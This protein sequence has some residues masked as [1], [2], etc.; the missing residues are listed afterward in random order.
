MMGRRQVT[1]SLGGLLV[2]AALG[3]C[4]GSDGGSGPPSL[5]SITVAPSTVTL[6][7]G[8]SQSFAATGHFSDNSTESVA[9]TWSATGG[10]ITSAGVYTAGTTPGEYRVIATA[11]GGALADTAAVTIPA[12]PPPNLVAIEVTPPTATVAAGQSQTFTALG[13]LSDNSTTAVPVAWT[14][15]G[16]TVS[17]GGVYTAGSTAGSFLVIATEIGGAA[18]ADTATVTV[19]VSGPVLIGV[20]ITTDSVRAH[21]RDTATVAAVGRYSNNTEGPVTVTWSTTA[22][23]T[24]GSISPTGTFTATSAALGAYKIIATSG[25]YADTVPVVTFET[26][27]VTVSGPTFWLPTAP[28]GPTVGPA[29]VYLCTSNHYTDDAAGLGG[30]ATVTATPNVGVLQPTVSYTTNAATVYADGS[31]EVSVVC[32]KVWEA[33]VGLAGTVNVSISVASNRPGSGM[34]K[35]FTY[36][37]NAVGPQSP[38]YPTP[39]PSGRADFVTQQDFTPNMT[40]SV[41]T[42]SYTV[43]ASVGANI[44]FKST[45]VP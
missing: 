1:A 24:A 26:A 13:R 45:H 12:P 6:A 16:G 23:L 35:I 32:Q 17:A 18:F 43:S 11:Q 29:A 33:P 41:V 42:E 8:A 21:A 36:A 28:S 39:P 5:E 20:R 31:A 22:P 7:A 19:T 44:W 3:A 37:S 15:T 30:T 14:A 40:T 38:H 10:T 34:A 25:A 2:A 9:A 4:G 27:G